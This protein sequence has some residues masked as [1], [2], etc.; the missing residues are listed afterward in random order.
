MKIKFINQLKENSFKGGKSQAMKDWEGIMKNE[1]QNSLAAFFT[2]TAKNPEAAVEVL[3]SSIASQA[4][5]MTDKELLDMANAAGIVDAALMA[6]VTKSPHATVAGYLRSLMASS[7]GFVESA[8]T[9]GQ[10][11]LEEFDGKTPTTEQLQELFK[12]E[13]KINEFRRKAAI[14]GGSI[15]L[16]DLLGGIVVQGSVTTAMTKNPGKFKKVA[17]ATTAGVAEGTV[18]ATGEIVSTLAIG[19]EIDRIAVWQEVLGQTPQAVSDI[20]FSLMRPN[21]SIKIGNQKVSKQRFN[22][23][24]E[25]ASVEEFAAMDIEIKNDK[26]LAN[27]VKQ[28]QQDGAIQP[29]L[30]AFE[31]WLFGKIMD[32]INAFNNQEL[33]WQF[34]IHGMAEA[35]NVMRYQAPDIN[36]HRKPGKY[37]WHMDVG[38]GPVPSMRKLSYSILLNPGE[39]EGGELCFHI[40]RNT[41]PYPGQTEKDAIGNMVLFPSYCVHRVLPMTKGTRYA[42]VG[43]AH[44]NSFK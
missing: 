19:E 29:K 11:L 37:D 9:F 44:G 17:I 28:K 15:Y 8:S 21:A 3:V 42:V 32:A 35:P 13:N 2:A 30:G 38:P 16:V 1:D 27:K 14:K 4:R 12:D 43:W 7:G 33:G 39:Y 24:M 41:D 23:I 20:G 36:K 18:G 6:K 5:V 22:E 10:F 40:G 25:N 31:D 34:D 26:S